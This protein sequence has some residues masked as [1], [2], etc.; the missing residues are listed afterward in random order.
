MTLQQLEYI[1]AVNHYKH[2]V[3]A[4]EA[5]R[6]TQPT[7]STMVQKLEEELN[8]QIF[9]R[10]KHPIATTAIGQKIVL[11]AQITL[12]E[13]GRL[14]EIVTS[15]V[16]SL[17]GSLKMAVIPTVAPYLI[18]DFIKNFKKQYAE[19]ALSIVEMRTSF[20]IEQLFQASLDMAILSTPLK[21]QELLEIP[22]YY[23]K[24]V[25]YFS[26]DYP[27]KDQVMMAAKMPLDDLWV[28]QEGHCIR[29]QV[30]NF[31]KKM[32]SKK[33]IYEAGSI[34]T[35]IKIVDK[36][37]GFTIIPELHLAFL[38]E[39]QL[40]NIRM[41]DNPP[42]VREISIVI[43]KDFVKE[44]MINAVADTVKQIIPQNML[45]DRLKKFSIKL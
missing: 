33:S 7:L 2:F 19:V 23:E 26:P 40:Q 3:K 24:F 45:D 43:R 12:N 1:V 34:D 5:C 25:A 13:L 29:N 14:N 41:I 27:N 4:A 15:E 39:N 31:C 8:V 11:Q 10:T 44:R 18:P 35:L 32:T 16:K 21:N 9:D 20:I 30:F 42:A 36:N 38:T 22:L 17:S 37:G 28:L 6:V